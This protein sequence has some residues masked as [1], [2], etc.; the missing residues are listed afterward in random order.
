MHG[1]DVK[2]NCYG[3]RSKTLDIIAEVGLKSEK[4]EEANNERTSGTTYSF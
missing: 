1:L 4:K 3:V 2:K